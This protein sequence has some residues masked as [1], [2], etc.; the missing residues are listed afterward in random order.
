[1]QGAFDNSYKATFGDAG[2][3]AK[4]EERLGQVSIASNSEHRWLCASRGFGSGIWHTAAS[5]GVQCVAYPETVPL[6]MW[7]KAQGWACFPIQCK[8][9]LCYSSARSIAQCCPPALLL[10][11]RLTQED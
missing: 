4:A 9:P 1:M 5:C 3:G 7:E 10:G 6:P 11:K 2:W 8:D